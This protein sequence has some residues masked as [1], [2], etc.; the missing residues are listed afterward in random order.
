MLPFSRR[1]PMCSHP[2]IAAA[3][4]ARPAHSRRHSHPSHRRHASHVIFWD[5]RES[6][7]RLI[8]INN[9]QALEQ[10]RC[11]CAATLR[12]LGLEFFFLRYSCFY[13]ELMMAF[14]ALVVVSRHLVHLFCRDVLVLINIIVSTCQ[15]TCL[16]F[17]LPQLHSILTS[18]GLTAE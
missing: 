17:L 10:L 5:I 9:C 12:A 11:V 2:R 13:L 1:R 7:I 3:V 18:G 16:Q 6:V 14:P 15:I 8:R 4:P